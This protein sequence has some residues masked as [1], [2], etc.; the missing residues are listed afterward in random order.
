MCIKQIYSM[1][2]Q[3]ILSIMIRNK[4]SIHAVLTITALWLEINEVYSTYDYC[5]MIRN[6]RS[7]HTVLTI[8]ALWLEINEV[9]IQYLRLLHYDKKWSKCTYCTYDDCEGSNQF[10]PSTLPG[11]IDLCAAV[12]ER[13]FLTALKGVSE[14]QIRRIKRRHLECRV[15]LCE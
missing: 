13:R 14:S 12:Y 8:T 3:N 11:V 15:I 4:R 5:I 7:I 10:C 2:A 6:K 9:Y 1:T